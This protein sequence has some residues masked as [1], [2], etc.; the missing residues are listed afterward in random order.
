MPGIAQALDSCVHDRSLPSLDSHPSVR[1]RGQEINRDFGKF[2][3]WLPVKCL[4]VNVA[5]STWISSIDIKS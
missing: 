4:V 5:D 1:E 2:Q 3:K